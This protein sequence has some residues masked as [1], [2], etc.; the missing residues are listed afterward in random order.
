MTAPVPIGFPDYG[1]QLSESQVVE[2]YDVGVTGN[3]IVQ[4]PIRPVHLAKTL[5][6]IFRPLTFPLNLAV[7]FY[8]DAAGLRVLDSYHIDCDLA[9]KA[10]Q[11]V[12]VLGPYVGF[13][14]GPSAAGNYQYTLEVWH[15]PAFGYFSGSS[16]E[17]AAF[18]SDGAA[19]GGVTTLQLI[20]A[21]V[22]EGPAA[23]YAHMSGGNFVF[24]VFAR[25]SGGTRTPLARIDAG[26]AI[27]QPQQIWLPPMTINVQIENLAAGAQNYD[28]FMTRKRNV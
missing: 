5:G 4:Y 24:K 3:G 20:G 21:N 25:D 16:I 7:T 6:V 1:R 28:L 11:P 22:Q 26:M 8:A 10:R 12:P 18:S 27:T 17:A 2:V 14:V 9:T 19:I 15:Q 23:W 13:T